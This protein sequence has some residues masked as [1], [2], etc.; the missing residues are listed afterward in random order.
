MPLCYIT[1][2]DEYP[3]VVEL[4]N[5]NSVSRGNFDPMLEGVTEIDKPPAL[6]VG[7]AIEGSS[8]AGTSVN[9][10]SS[11]STF[12]PSMQQPLSS[13]SL[14]TPNGSSFASAMNVERVSS[15]C[16]TRILVKVAYFFGL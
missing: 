6:K 16:C 9:M 15:R 10:T 2:T 4:A 11:V 3:A 14:Q 8:V 1:S 13:S 12:A 5:L 7:T